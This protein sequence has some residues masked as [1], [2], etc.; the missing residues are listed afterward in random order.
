MSEMMSGK[1]R[2]INKTEKIT[3][4]KISPTWQWVRLWSASV[5]LGIALWLLMAQPLKGCEFS[6]FPECISPCPLSPCTLKPLIWNHHSAN[7]SAHRGTRRTGKMADKWLSASVSSLCPEQVQRLWLSFRRGSRLT[8]SPLK[9]NC[10]HPLTAATVDFIGASGFCT[11]H[12]YLASHTRSS[13]TSV[14][15]T[16]WVMDF[17]NKKNSPSSLI[18]LKWWEKNTKKQPIKT[19]GYCWSLM[20]CLILIL[21]CDNFF[22]SFFVNNIPIR[23]F[24]FVLSGCWFFCRKCK[25]LYICV[26]V[27]SP[28][29]ECVNKPCWTCTH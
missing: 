7:S 2:S 10:F 15:I 21:I 28:L 8:G 4:K 25:I 1:N 29:V 27:C 26:V 5:S 14:F 24:G 6:F 11:Y 22:S 3:E 23:F 16:T 12:Q 9:G 19:W 18:G 20:I 17:L 13:W